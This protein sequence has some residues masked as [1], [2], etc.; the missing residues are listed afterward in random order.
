M[1]P[2]PFDKIERAFVHNQLVSRR[3]F[4][5]LN[6]VNDVTKEC[7]RAVPDTSISGRGVVREIADLIAERGKPGTIVSDNGTELTNNAVLAW[8][9]EL[10]VEWH[11]I[12]PGKPM[13]NGFCESFNG[14]T[15]SELLY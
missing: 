11:Y 15:R 13:Q 8:C 5:V 2:E 1:Q 6:I 3:R 4:R 7:L 12:A 14:R 10:G 9:G